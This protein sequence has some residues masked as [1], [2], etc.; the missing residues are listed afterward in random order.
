MPLRFRPLPMFTLVTAAMLAV[1][2]SLGV[3]QVE[4]LHWKLGLIAQVNRNLTLPPV[5]LDEALAM[6]KA[7]EYRRVAL[8][9]YF[10]HGKEAYVYGIAPGGTPV[11]HV[12]TPFVPDEGPILLVDRGIVPEALR[13][14]AGRKAGQ[15][16]GE[17]HIVGVWRTPDPP[18]LFTPPPDLSRRIWFSR[19][20]KSIAAADRF[21]PAVPA[22]VEADAAPNPGG[23]PKGGQT[24][25]TFRNEHL[26]YA[27]TWF[28]LAATLLGVYIAYHV[29]KGRL[30]LK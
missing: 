10:E 26:Q 4:R 6:G 8:D 13:D 16:E 9:G 5:P 15:V 3:W 28:G 21:T 23:W 29:S 17:R 30:T 14:P 11:F 22:I 20:V 1:L 24:V 25:V 7:A 2:V 12:V 27:I 19:D 18:G